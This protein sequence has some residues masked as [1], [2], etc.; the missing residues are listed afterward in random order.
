MQLRGLGPAYLQYKDGLKLVTCHL[1]FKKRSQTRW[2]GGW[3]GGW[4][5]GRAGPS[6][7]PD[8]HR[9]VAARAP[10][11]SVQPGRPD[12][13]AGSKLEIE[14]EFNMKCSNAAAAP[15]VAQKENRK[16]VSARPSTKGMSDRCRRTNL[17]LSQQQTNILIQE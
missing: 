11:T 9:D 3:A 6:R 10:A 17:I 5:G 2:A 7:Q 13:S 8:K 14:L 15:V 4:E 16:P 12:N 1:S